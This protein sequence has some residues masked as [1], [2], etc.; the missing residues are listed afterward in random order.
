VPRKFLKVPIIEDS[1]MLSWPAYLRIFAK[2]QMKKYYPSRVEQD[3]K[4]EV[5]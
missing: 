5:T 1:D 3:E 2:S 4:E